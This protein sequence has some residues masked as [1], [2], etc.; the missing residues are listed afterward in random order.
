MTTIKNYAKILDNAKEDKTK[1]KL[2]LRITGEEPK[3][4]REG[5][6]RDYQWVKSMFSTLMKIPGYKHTPWKMK[7]L[8]KS[9][10]TIEGKRGEYNLDILYIYVCKHH[11]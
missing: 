8:S 4:N 2:F 11:N 1:Q 3:I 5:K 7:G 10:K 9:R 6:N